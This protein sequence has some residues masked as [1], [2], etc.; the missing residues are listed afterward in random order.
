MS[1]PSNAQCERQS[2]RD[3]SSGKYV[4][5]PCFCCGKGA[6]M[7]Y[8]SHE[9]TDRIDA[10]GENWGD[11]ALVLCNRCAKKTQGM[12][13]LQEYQAYVRSLEEAKK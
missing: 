2:L 7:D 1:I 5:N 4:K 12:R 13:T 11:A 10:N 3:H 8:Q 9:M 6:P